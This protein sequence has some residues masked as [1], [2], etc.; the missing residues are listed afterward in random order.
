MKIIT[1]KYGGTSVATK[2]SRKKVVSKIIE[3]HNED[4]NVVVVVSAI[5]RKEN[6]YSTDSLNALINKS[7]ISRREQDM[8][9]SCGEIISSVVLSNVLNEKGYKSIVYTGYQAGITTNKDFGKAEIIS[10]K[11]EKIKKSLNKG[12]IVIVAGFQGGNEEGEITTLGRG[13]SDITAVA[14]AKSLG[15]KWVE[16]YSDVD[17]IM[18]ADPSIVPDARSLSSMGYSEVYQ[19]AEDGAKIIHP[20]AVEI[21]RKYNIP[22]KIKNTFSNKQGTTVESVEALTLNGKK[23]FKTEKVITAITYKKNR[24]QVIIHI[25]EESENTEE[26]ME[27]LTSNNISIDLINFFIGKKVFTIDEEDLNMV[28]KILD[29]G[30]YNYELI[31]DCC[32][33]SSIGY[34][35]QGVP[36][37]MAR[38]VKALSKERIKILQTSDSHNTIWCLI[39]EKDT[40]KALTALHKEFKLYE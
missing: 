39:K 37:V 40:N 18:T 30:K 9:L 28:K 7:F 34:K 26:I 15:S 20:K 12:Y 1:Q 19:L 23:D 27:K 31:K 16:I 3:K 17:G 36:G 22:I 35:M 32:K 25:D 24:V 21:A 8:I 6:P 29:E 13:G 38:I 14:L 5:G 2:E 4:Y 11:P 10:I 33:L